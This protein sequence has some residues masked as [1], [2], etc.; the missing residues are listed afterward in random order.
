MSHVYFSVCLRLAAVQ[1]PLVM[2][3][4]VFPGFRIIMKW[5]SL[6]V[7]RDHFSSGIIIPKLGGGKELNWVTLKKEGRTQKIYKLHFMDFMLLLL[8]NIKLSKFM[9]SKN[10]VSWCK[11]DSLC[12]TLLFS[13][14]FKNPPSHFTVISWHFPPRWRE[15]SYENMVIYLF[16][17]SARA[18]AFALSCGWPFSMFPVCCCIYL[19]DILCTT[20]EL[21]RWHLF[22]WF[23]RVLGD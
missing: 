2:S 11:S 19:H 8:Y 7:S 23:S 4:L 15:S 14:I 10:A 16:D 21:R 18:C 13:Y 12:T 17:Y 3:V 22:C 6:Q 1:F 9:S 20:R 5:F